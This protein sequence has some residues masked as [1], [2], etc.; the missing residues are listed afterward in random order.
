[1]HELR[2]MPV[3]N[4]LSE[5]F[6]SDIADLSK[7]EIIPKLT[8]VRVGEREDDLAYEKGIHNPDCLIDYSFQL[9]LSVFRT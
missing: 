8:V 6:V 4:A 7:K 3:V 5:K 2:G 9:L 1:M